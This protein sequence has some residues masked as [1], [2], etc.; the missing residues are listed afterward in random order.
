MGSSVD[1]SV[2]GTAV[3]SSATHAN[4]IAPARSADAEL[5]PAGKAG[6]GQVSRL[7]LIAA[8]GTAAFALANAF[9]PHDA[10]SVVEANDS[11]RPRPLAAGGDGPP[12]A[13]KRPL[14]SGIAAAAARDPFTGTSFAPPPPPPVVA[15]PPPPP[16]PPKAPA[17]P[18]AFVGLLEQGVGKP[19]AF[20]SRG[21]ALLV[22]SAGDVIDNDYRIESL[23]PSVIVLTYLPLKER[24][25]LSVTGAQP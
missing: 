25:R 22:V 13:V 20:L 23:S 6:R 12:P 19:A 4:V 16:P 21:D 9:A 7:A 18:F 1:G 3:P 5:V 17:L 11:R 2:S 10:A 24:Q 8:A 15:P 14:R